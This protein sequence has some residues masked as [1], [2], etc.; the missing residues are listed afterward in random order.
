MTASELQII[1]SKIFTAPIEI[2]IILKKIL[3]SV[4]YFIV[5]PF[6]LILVLPIG[7]ISLWWYSIRIYKRVK[8]ILPKIS[9]NEVTDLLK[10]IVNSINDIELLKDNKNIPFLAKPFYKQIMVIQKEQK[11]IVELLKER[12]EIEASLKEDI[13]MIKKQQ[14]IVSHEGTSVLTSSEDFFAELATL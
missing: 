11:K 6:L 1:D 8:K 12:L 2:G 7:Y 9:E 14:T 13:E 5:I 4:G 3:G 10:S